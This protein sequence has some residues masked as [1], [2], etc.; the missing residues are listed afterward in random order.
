MKKIFLKFTIFYCWLFFAQDKTPYKIYDRVG[1][2][3]SYSKMLSLTSKNDVVLF[4]EL[5]NYSICQWLQLELSKDLAQKK[6]YC[7]RCRND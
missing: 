6:E 1:Q 5:H 4:G 2:E 3:M 7:F